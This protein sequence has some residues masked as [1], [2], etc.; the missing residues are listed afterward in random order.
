MIT[1]LEN[2]ITERFLKFKSLVTSSEFPVYANTLGTDYD[3]LGKNDTYYSHTFIQRPEDIGYT[4]SISGQTCLAMGV[5]DEILAYN[6]INYHMIFR[7]NL[8]I[9]HHHLDNYYGW[10]CDHQFPHSNLLIYLNSFDD[11]IIQVKN[12]DDVIET[13]KPKENE[14]LLFGGQMHRWGPTPVG[15]KRVSIVSTLLLNR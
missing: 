4:T 15:Q 2:P 8:N 3:S 5:I 9:T 10:H 12:S 1:V 6:K 11:G 7:L 14:I 13:Y